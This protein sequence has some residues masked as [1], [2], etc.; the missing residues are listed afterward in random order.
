MTEIRIYDYPNKQEL[1]IKYMTNILA[2]K[3]TVIFIFVSVRIKN[4]IL[5]QSMHC[6]LSR[7]LVQELLVKD[8]SIGIKFIERI[9]NICGHR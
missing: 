9:R 1:N 4:L 7:I 2:Q 5:E 6:H 3:Q 8:C